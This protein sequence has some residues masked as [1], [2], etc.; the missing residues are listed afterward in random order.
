M[1][2]ET[3]IQQQTF[4]SE[5]QKALLNILFTS[6]YL[7]AIV[8][9]FFK[10]YDITR[11]Q[12]N[13]MRSVKGQLPKAASIQLI[14]DRMLD[15]MSDASRIVERLRLKNMVK[16]EIS[17][18]DKRIVHI[19]IT[20]EGIKLLESIE[21]HVEEMEK[22]IKNLSPEEAVQLNKLLDKIRG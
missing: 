19:S 11:Q 15:K 3:D 22:S 7:I 8:N 4:R 6:N 2:L 21:M 1:S 16:R 13:V 10:P 12:Y 17:P 9:D 20:D 14:R 18:D 5:Y